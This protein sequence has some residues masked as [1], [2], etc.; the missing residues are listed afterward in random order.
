MRNMRL[1]AALG[2]AGVLAVTATCCVVGPALAADSASTA[3]EIVRGGEP[4][5]DVQY[6]GKEFIVENYDKWDKIAEEYAPEIIRY[7]NGQLVQRTPTEY[8]CPH[9][10]QQSWTISYN[11][12]YLDADNRGCNSCHADLNAMIEN[13]EYKHATIDNEALETYGDVNQ[14]ISCHRDNGDDFGRLIHAIH[15]NERSGSKFAEGSN[16]T[17]QSCHDATADGNGMQLW[18]NVK[19]DALQGINQVE[20]VQGEFSA[21]QDK[22]QS[23]SELYSYDFVH[24]YY[25]HMRYACSPA[26]LDIDLPQSMFD[27]WEITIDGNVNEPY[28]AK[29]PELVAEA[30]AAGVVVT[31]PSKMVC[32][33]NPIGGGGIG[34]AEITGIPVSWL[35][36]KA[37]GYTEGTNSVRAIRA[38]GSS[39]S[40]FDLSVLDK[41][42]L[43]YKIGGEYLDA[44]HG[45]PV[46][47]W[48]ETYDAQIFSKQINGYHVT[49]DVMDERECGQVNQ[50][51]A[52]VN[53]PNVTVCGVP[54]GL[55]I[56]NGQPFTF[57]GYAD[58]FDHPM[59]TVEF[60][61]DGGET[62]TSFDVGDVDPA[63]W[64]WWSFTFTPEKEGAYVLSVRGTDVDGEVSYRDHEVLVNAKDEMPTEDEITEIGKIVDPALADGETSGDQQ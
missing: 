23:Q 58:A 25:D 56:Q 13:M 59:K 4:D 8:E 15:F 43:V 45:F 52:H 21:T 5:G 61:M 30:E 51:G 10:M 14:C 64:L 16:G 18:D 39:R 3:D 38:D 48:Q 63:K 41:G 55:I 49:S 33:L 42:Y 34:Q 29:L 1:K 24:G 31:K 53:R 62:W 9:W 46:T 44:R 54:E 32:E 11:T 22:V 2:M 28:T 27:E 7:A 50:E 47:H 19:H 17:C 20:N 36:E 57:N 37:G 60:S 35:I 12:Y 40:G 26:G 6:P